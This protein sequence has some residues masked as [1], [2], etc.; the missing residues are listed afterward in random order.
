MTE[1]TETGRH[2]EEFMRRIDQNKD[3]LP[4]ILLELAGLQRNRIEELPE[5][6]QQA[7]QE[8]LDIFREHLGGPEPGQATL[9]ET[10]G[11]EG[12]LCGVCPFGAF[13]PPDMGFASK[14]QPICLPW[15]SVTQP[16]VA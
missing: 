10:C 11:H 3:E 9:V 4:D 14:S 8:L 13:I 7:I 1:R 16:S 5:P 15:I 2:T 12:A 6:S